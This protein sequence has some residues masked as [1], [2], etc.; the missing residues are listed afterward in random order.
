M[1]G[2]IERLEEMKRHKNRDH[3][4]ILQIKIPVELRDQLLETLHADGLKIKD[5][6]MA[7]I[8]EYL[9]SKSQNT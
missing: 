3:E 9:E 4:A 2:L 6:F 1:S 5:L 8:T 7:A